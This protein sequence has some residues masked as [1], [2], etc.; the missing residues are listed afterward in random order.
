[1]N[2]TSAGGNAATGGT[3]SAN[4][5]AIS[6]STGGKTSTS[7]ATGGTSSTS[8]SVAA[9]C[10]ASITAPKTTG[11]LGVTSGY[12]S[13][14]TYAGY[15]FTWTGVKSI[16]DTCVTPK[17]GDT[18]CLPSFGA[19]ALCGAGVVAMDP[20]Y[21]SIAGVGFNLKQA[22]DAPNPAQSVVAGSTITVGA[23]FTDST[24]NTGNN[25]ARVQIVDDATPANN[26]C[27]D[28]GAWTPGQP[29]DTSTFNTHCWAPTETGALAFAAGTKIVSVHIVIPSDKTAERPFS[30]CLTDF[31]M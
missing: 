4:T 15:G 30:F 9:S 21:N 17:C 12:V 31:Q 22:K 11:T 19:T 6:G 20:D 3:S 26:Y 18:G 23:T 29:I 13:A 2:N 5:S 7:G 24:T 1:V 8:T 25:F 27:V 28:V 16:G 10:P 14:S